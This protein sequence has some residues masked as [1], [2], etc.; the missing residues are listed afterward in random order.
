MYFVLEIVVVTLLILTLIF[1]IILN[2]K[3]AMLKSGSSELWRLVQTIDSSIINA[4]GGIAE[5][6]KTI[7]DA[8]ETLRK[9]IAQ[10]ND[11]SGEMPFLTDAGNKSAD[12]LEKLVNE[13]R[14]VI[15][16]IE[17][18]VRAW[19]VGVNG[20]CK[21]AAV[22]NVDRYN[23]DEVKVGSNYDTSSANEDAAMLLSQYTSQSIASQLSNVSQ[24]ASALRNKRAQSSNDNSSLS[25]PR[26]S[27]QSPLNLLRKR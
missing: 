24:S 16:N 8:Y 1:C 2:K 27:K 21:D 22:N 18:L 13:A 6:K 14:I 7:S 10:A 4:R 12:K 25:Y 23:N 20:R 11:L 26:L 9:L 15:K 17:K 3:L 5:L 19:G